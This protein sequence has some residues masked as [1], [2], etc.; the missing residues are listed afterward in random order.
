MQRLAAMYAADGA[1]S[2]RPGPEVLAAFGLSG[3]SRVLPGGQQE[4]HR[5][6]DVVL[7]PAVND[8]EAT[9]TQELLRGL[10]QDGFRCADPIPTLDGRWT[11]GGWIANR[12]IPG[13]RPAA[14]D[15][16]RVADAGLVFSDAAQAARPADDAPLSR[17][18]H[19]WA[20]A[21][22]VAWGEQT[23][24]LPG[25]ANDVLE[26]LTARLVEVVPRAVQVVHGDLSGNVFLDEHDEAVVLDVSPY[27]RPRDW[28]TAIVVVDAVLWCGAEASVLRSFASDAGRTDLAIRALIFRLAAERPEEAGSKATVA[29]YRGAME[30]LR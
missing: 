25:P 9:W 6:D 12:F 30:S 5:V 14:P 22:R 26:E 29:T 11:E 23:I 17:R 10:D 24:D 1:A 8:A 13:L 27:I 3:L 19:R 7:K 2:P 15:W 28:A 21:D 20:V 16:D 4:A 18:T